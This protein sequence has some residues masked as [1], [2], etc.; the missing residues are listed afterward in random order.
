MTGRGVSCA[1]CAVPIEVGPCEK[2][3]SALIA[4]AEFHFCQWCSRL[5]S[6][7]CADAENVGRG[8][9]HWL[10]LEVQRLAYDAPDRFHNVKRW[11]TFPIAKRIGELLNTGVYRRVCVCRSC[12]AVRSGVFNGS[13]LPAWAG[14]DFVGPMPGPVTVERKDAVV[15]RNQRETRSGEF[16]KI[17]DCLPLTLS[18]MA[19]SKRD[20]LGWVQLK[21]ER[22]FGPGYF[23]G[24]EFVDLDGVC[25]AV[26]GEWFNV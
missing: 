1:L 17:S 15:D 20:P 19:K 18:A 4:G 10:A 22:E 2:M 8:C 14:P 6:S 11:Q 7:L 9:L 21:C 16:R 25:H 5:M 3:P 26:P 12:V 24:P 23:L 13:Y